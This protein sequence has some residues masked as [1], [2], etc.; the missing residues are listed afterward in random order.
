VATEGAAYFQTIDSLAQHASWQMGIPTFGGVNRA[1]AN[2]AMMVKSEQDTLANYVAAF[3]MNDDKGKMRPEVRRQL[4]LI[5]S[6]KSPLETLGFTTP[7]DKLQKIDEGI[8]V[9]VEKMSGKDGG[10]Q[11]TAVNG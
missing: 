2:Q 9:M 11:V 10:V 8:G 3:G 4:D 7:E 5:K 6:L 1:A